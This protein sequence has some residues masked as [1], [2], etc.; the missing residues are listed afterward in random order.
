M[1]VFGIAMVALEAMLF[2]STRRYYS[3]LSNNEHALAFDQ[4]L[5][6]KDFRELTDVYPRALTDLLRR[7][8]AAD[9]GD[10]VSL[11][12]AR[13]HIRAVREQISISGAIKLMEDEEN[14]APK[15]SYQSTREE[16]SSILQSITNNS[17]GESRLNFVPLRYIS[18][19][20]PRCA[21]SQCKSLAA[22]QLG[23][24][25]A[26]RKENRLHLSNLTGLQSA[27]RRKE[28]R[29][30]RAAET[31]GLSSLR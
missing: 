13:E 26:Q 25:L 8:V 27:S 3:N 19:E 6:E 5:L 30:G 24:S 22:S 1:D 2:N 9:P 23:L 7:M 4:R 17:N 16:A 18:K 12:D 28:C 11:A 15:L 10:R 29:T 21:T 20:K 31:G 14:P